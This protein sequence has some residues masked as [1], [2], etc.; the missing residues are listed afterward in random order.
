MPSSSEAFVCLLIEW[1]DTKTQNLGLTQ[2]GDTRGTFSIKSMS[3]YNKNCIYFLYYSLPFNGDI[4]SRFTV[5]C[6]SHRTI[7]PI[8]QRF[9]RL[10]TLHDC[11]DLALVDWKRPRLE[12]E[13]QLVKWN[14]SPFDLHPSYIDT[15]LEQTW[16]SAPSYRRNEWKPKHFNS[17][18]SFH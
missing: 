14:D 4:F 17:S 16:V 12:D 9:Y 13:H 5:P 10:I 1:S 15:K 7:S 6:Q 11:D 3:E 8:T 2:C 18:L